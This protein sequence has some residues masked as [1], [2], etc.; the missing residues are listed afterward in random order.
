[1]K[2]FRERASQTANINWLD[3]LTKH[4]G[5][6][7]RKGLSNP[8]AQKEMMRAYDVCHNPITQEQTCPSREQSVAAEQ[9]GHERRSSSPRPYRTASS[10][11]PPSPQMILKTQTSTF[12]ELQQHRGKLLARERPAPRKAEA[13]L[14]LLAPPHPQ[15]TAPSTLLGNVHTPTRTIPEL[16]SHSYFHTVILSQF[17]KH[18][19]LLG[20]GQGAAPYT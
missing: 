16:G 15:I 7:L 20:S 2:E 10:H 13:P 18:I 9:T 14:K 12:S 8:N 1:M 19:H 6:F 11:Q 4:L 17:P 5:V 3:R